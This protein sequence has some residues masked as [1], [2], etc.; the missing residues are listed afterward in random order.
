MSHICRHTIASLQKALEELSQTNGRHEGVPTVEVVRG[1]RGGS[2]YLY[3]IVHY[4]L[5]S[6]C[7]T[8]YNIIV[9]YTLLYYTILYMLYITL[10]T[11]VSTIQYMYNCILDYTILYSVYTV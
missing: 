4:T 1:G 7:T 11:C 8:V 5:C 2:L 6:T 3:I 9:Y 10:Y